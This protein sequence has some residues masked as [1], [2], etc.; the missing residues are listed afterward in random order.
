[1]LIHILLSPFDVYRTLAS[2]NFEL[3]TPMAKV[4]AASWDLSMELSVLAVERIFDWGIAAQDLEETQWR[5]LF[6]SPD[7]D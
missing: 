7:P 4:E 3:D 1:M 6:D 2:A 5:S